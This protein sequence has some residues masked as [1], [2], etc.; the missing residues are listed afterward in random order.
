MQKNASDIHLRLGNGTEI[1]IRVAAHGTIRVRMS[2]CGFAQQSGLFRYGV[3]NNADSPSGYSLSETGETVAIHAGQSILHIDRRDG[4]IVFCDEQNRELVRTAEAPYIREKG[5]FVIR[6]VMTEE[7][8]LYG[9]GDVMRDRIQKRGV[10]ARM[11]VDHPR[12]Y[13]PVP[14]LMSSRGWAFLSNTTW[15]HTFDLG[16]TVAHEW[17]VD[18]PH[19]G[20]LDFFLFAGDGYGALLDR[21]TDVAGKPVLLP[22]WAYG[23][24][25]ICNE[26]ANS[27]EVVE[28]ALKF[29]REDIPCDLI[30]LENSWTEHRFD[31][32]TSKKWHPERFYIPTPAPKG[33]VSFIGALRRLGFKLSLLLGCNYDLSLEEDRLE[34]RSEQEAAAPSEESWYAHLRAFVDEGV[35]AFKLNGN[36]QLIEHPDRQWGNGMSDREMHNL[37]P[38]LLSKQM[39]RGYRAQTGKRPMVYSI[40][41]Y[42][43][44]QQYA[45]TFAGRA[46]NDGESLVSLL[47]HSLSGHANTTCDMFIHT[48]EGIHL[49]FMLPWAQINSWRYFR[50]PSFLD[51]KLSELFKKYAKLR[52]ELIP[53]LYAAAHAA[54]RTGMPILRAMPIAF[55]ADPACSDMIDQYMLG[56]FLLVGVF[57]EQVYLPEGGWIDYWTGERYQ[58]SKRF[59]Y[60]IPN[61]AGG[62]LFIRIGA[63]IPMWPVM[64]NI[65]QQPVDR[66]AIHVY[67]GGNSRF[68]MYE[69]DGTTFRYEEG[70]VAETAICCEADERGF[71]LKLAKSGAYEGMPARRGYNIF[72]HVDKKP[73]ALAIDGQLEP[74][75]TKSARG[76]HGHGWSYD[77]TSGIVRV[78]VED[79]AEQGEELR[80]EVKYPAVAGSRTSERA[81]ILDPTRHFD[82]ESRLAKAVESDKFEEAETAIRKWW[83][84]GTKA[85]G[86]D[87]E[88][89]TH[90]LAGCLLM[91]RLAAVRGWS[92]RT[93][94]GDDYV[95]LFDQKSVSGTQQGYQLLMR[96]LRRLSGYAH[97]PVEPSVHPLVREAL[98]WIEKELAGEL[99]L[100]AVA[101]RLH[102]HPSHLSRLFKKDVGKPFSDYV[103]QKRM[104]LGKTML[105]SGQKVYEAAA[106]TGFK[107]ASY[108]S[109][110]YRHY[111]GVAPK[112]CKVY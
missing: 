37:Y 11:W 85:S 70:E 69:D 31:I 4:R 49:G 47:N 68:V 38:V 40:A 77:R 41:G 82:F 84:T 42:T 73:S 59:D 8:R 27:R 20:E 60:A 78:F 29:R 9:L 2:R 112:E 39:H 98:H 101:E 17:S 66:I 21:Y 76:G 23:L 96:L 79:R 83:A 100:N 12:G 43:G 16:R 5:G 64:N 65:G 33:E 46:E 97:Q 107:D 32:S 48:K 102:V 10:T 45:A 58:G 13:A 3:L 103:M 81:N 91:V 54:N 71:V 88:W 89:R 106:L 55:P 7:E 14:F 57:T 105:L 87:D 67:P 62:P 26:N 18:S 74:E 34:Q 53:Y 109:R 30:G 44:F 94:Y 15:E 25:Y 28:D 80:I 61:G 108:F 75:R 111:W 110:V 35:S 63:I 51:D 95:H 93:V 1:K 56:E 86:D 72:L 52:Y 99:S 50:H 92:A 104:E 22:I 36:E 6:F 24:T 19:G 90:L